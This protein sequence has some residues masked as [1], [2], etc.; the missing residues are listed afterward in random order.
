VDSLRVGE[1]LFLMP[2][3]Q[4]KYDAMALALR[5]DD[6]VVLVGYCPRYLTHDVNEVLG[7]SEPDNIEVTIERVNR[8]APLNLRLMCKLV[9]PW[10]EG[11]KPCSDE[12]YQPLA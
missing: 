7:K 4:N 2:D 6:P 10:P 9:S 8:D 12:D 5:T 11:F 1:R 3:P